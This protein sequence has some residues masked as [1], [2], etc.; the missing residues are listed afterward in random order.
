MS[1][2]RPVVNTSSQYFHFSFSIIENVS[3]NITRERLYESSKLFANKQLNKTPE[4]V[5]DLKLRGSEVIRR[6]A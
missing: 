6:E 5:S 4:P 1:K 3:K 2:I